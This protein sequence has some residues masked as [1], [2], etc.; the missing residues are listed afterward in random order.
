[1]TKE[2]RFSKEFDVLRLPPTDP[3]YHYRFLNK[4]KLNLERKKAM[5]YEIVKEEEGKRLKEKM[6]FPDT[7][8]VDNTIQRGDV[9]LAKVKREVWEDR[10]KTKREKT[11]AFT[12]AARDTVERD[13]EKYGVKTFD[14]SD[15]K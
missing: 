8:G 14:E 7:P 13:G 2:R 3:A 6:E 11:R 9:I 5:G 12:K 4:N 1:M 10:E 15:K